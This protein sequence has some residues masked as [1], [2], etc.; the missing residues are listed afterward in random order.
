MW[1]PKARQYADK[2]D[3]QG[4]TST[5]IVAKHSQQYVSSD[6]VH[7]GQARFSS[8]ATVRLLAAVN[9]VIQLMDVPQLG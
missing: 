9:A 1:C 3:L 5:G 7:M 4:C 8:V 6:R 2:I